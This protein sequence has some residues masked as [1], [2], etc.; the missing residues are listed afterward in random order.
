MT[1]HGVG[2]GGLIV[3]EQAGPIT[4]LFMDE[5]IEHAEPATDVVGGVFSGQGE[6]L[7]QELRWIRMRAPGQFHE[8]E[9]DIIG[10]TG[11]DL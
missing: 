11:P 1:W 6:P 8:D 10:N 5:A 2:A 3:V 9:L 4:V 7:A